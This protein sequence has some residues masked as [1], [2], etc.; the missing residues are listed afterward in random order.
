MCKCLRDQSY[1]ILKL[2][3][4]IMKEEFMYNN[5]KLKLDPTV[6]N[7]FFCFNKMIKKYEKTFAW[8]SLCL[9]KVLG[10]NWRD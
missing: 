9:L 8:K 1:G 2:G 10:N 4:N 3:L 5:F 7:Y 6:F